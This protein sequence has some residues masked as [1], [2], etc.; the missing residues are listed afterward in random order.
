M[1]QAGQ[2]AVLVSL[3]AV[4][5]AS[6]LATLFW[7]R[8]DAY[9]RLWSRVIAC[10]TWLLR[11]AV[12][13]SPGHHANNDNFRFSQVQLDKLVESAQEEKRKTEEHFQTIADNASVMLW[14]SNADG[15][16]TFVNKPCS[17][18]TGRPLLP[19]W[20]D[21]GPSTCIQM[22][23]SA[24]CRASCQLPRPARASEENTA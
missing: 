5:L 19:R 13:L 10:R 12:F 17:N 7:L 2:F 8:K 14:V 23:F 24:F 16:V 11:P 18:F 3:I 22:T 15:A 9:Q 1:I 20:T 4:G 21:F 6:S